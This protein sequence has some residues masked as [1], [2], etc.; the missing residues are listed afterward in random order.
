MEFTFWLW[1]KLLKEMTAHQPSFLRV[2]TE[3]MSIRIVQPSQLDITID[4]YREAVYMWLVHILTTDG[5]AVPSRLARFSSNCV[6]STCL[7]NPNYWSRRLA[8]ILAIER[9]DQS[10]KAQWGDLV[11]A[12][13]AQYDDSPTKGLKQVDTYTVKDHVE[14]VNA[15]IANLEE[16]AIADSQGR[17]WVKWKGPW[18]AKPI[19]MV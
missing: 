10:I 5:W 8:T 9:A 6:I 1:D 18:V 13:N 14:Q 3:E 4:A 15:Q 11:Q 19:G 12:S 2:L 7:M 17:G 16:Q